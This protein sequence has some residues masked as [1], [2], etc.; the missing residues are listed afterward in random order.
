M[1]NDKTQYTLEKAINTKRGKLEQDNKRE[2]KNE[3]ELNN[4]VKTMKIYSS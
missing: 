3:R 1:K 4:T 2:A